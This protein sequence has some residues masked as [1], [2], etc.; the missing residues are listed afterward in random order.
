MLSCSIWFSAQSFW[1]GGGL[2]SRCVGC[3]Y[4]ADGAVRLG[5]SLYFMRKMHGQTT[6]KFTV[7]NFRMFCIKTR[8]LR[9]KERKKDVSSTWVQR[10]VSI[11]QYMCLSK[12]P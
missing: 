4:G 10:R 12:I 5:I 3:V 9:K 11:A 8:L 2:D 7:E 1:I 6:I